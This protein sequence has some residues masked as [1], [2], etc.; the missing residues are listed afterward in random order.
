MSEDVFPG[1]APRPLLSITQ[2]GL[3]VGLVL[4]VVAGVW[5]FTAFLVTLVLGAIGGGV[6]LV[7]DGRLD[8]RGLVERGRRR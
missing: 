6:G 2:T 7:L 5:G 4:G 3:L 1:P 8:V